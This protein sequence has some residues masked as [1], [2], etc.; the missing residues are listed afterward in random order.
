MV[1]ICADGKTISPTVIYKCQS[2]STACHQGNTLYAMV[3]HSPKGWTDRGIGQ[4]WIVD[5]DKKTS[6]KADGHA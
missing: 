4:L 2:F 1:T 3:A 6:E 5:F